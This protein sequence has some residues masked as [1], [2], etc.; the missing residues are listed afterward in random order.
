MAERGYPRLLALAGES[1]RTAV[2]QPVP[3]IIL[4]LLVAAA[5]G[6]ILGTVGQTAAAE[7]DVLAR[8]DEAGTRSIVLVD[9]QG[10]AGLAPEAVERIVSLSGVEWAIGFGP[11]VDFRNS[12]LD[13]G[14]PAAV[15]VVYGGLPGEPYVTTASWDGRAGIVL[16]GP[17]AQAVL[18]LAAPV[19]GLTG[20]TEHLAVVGWLRAR[21]PLEFL[22]NGVVAAPDP[23]ATDP[24]VRSIQVLANRPEDVAAVAEAARALAGAEDPTSL[25][26]ETS[27]AF[28]QLR[29]AVAGEL[30]RYSRQLVIMVLVVAIA[31]VGL[32]VYG[33]VTTRKRD[34]GRRRALG[35][36][37]TTLIGLVVTQTTTIAFTGALIGSAAG[38]WAAWQW[39]G[40]TPDTSFIVA[41][42]TLCILSAVAASLPPATIA[43]YRDPVRIL[44]VP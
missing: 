17:G 40:S 18:G 3:T 1:I 16:V 42:S 20:T 11:A 33:S 31:L 25:A 6:V 43:A 38:T 14:R 29:A 32:T 21:E 41:V 36:S 15:R 34:F 22:N 23:R 30:G 44:R 35:A 4:G 24:T 12:E 37:R 9:T 5:A 10:R 19:G 7:A 39:S 13:G 28:A 2:S 27:E 8:I 26:V